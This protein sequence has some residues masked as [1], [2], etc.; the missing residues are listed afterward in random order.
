[1]GNEAGLLVHLH[2]VYFMFYFMVYVVFLCYKTI[3]LEHFH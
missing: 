1:M 2:D 3:T